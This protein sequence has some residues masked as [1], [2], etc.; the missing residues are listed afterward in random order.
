MRISETVDYI[1]NKELVRENESG[2]AFDFYELINLISIILGCT[3]M[4]FKIFDVG[5]PTSDFSK[6]TIFKISNQV[7]L[8]DLQFFKFI[9]SAA[10]VH[11]SNTNR[12]IGKTK[13]KNEFFPYAIW[14]YKSPFS[15]EL[16]SDSCDLVLLSWSGKANSKSEYYR[17]CSD[18]FYEF[19]QKV[20]DTIKL[21]MPKVYAI[22]N[23][24]VKNSSFKRIKSEK[25]FASYNDYL[26]YLYCLLKKH[27]R[28]GDFDDAGLTI[29]RGIFQNDLIS[30]EFK[31]YLKVKVA[32]F[33]KKMHEN[34]E[35]IGQAY[36]FRDLRLFDCFTLL[37]PERA[38]YVGEKFL[39]YL[40]SE[41][42][43]EIISGQKLFFD[44]YQKHGNPEFARNLLMTDMKQL[45]K[46]D[47][48]AKARTYEDLFELTLEATYLFWKERKELC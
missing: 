23:E 5:F 16:F 12:F 18:E 2:E 45:F 7:R 1:N 32:L 14:K 28:T 15:D 20:V 13:R 39:D 47:E 10:S 43:Q 4:L 46:N 27:S 38:S 31:D 44:V 19:A 26:D 41:A 29:T 25:A 37:N 48:L 9:R 30:T 11:P 6:K 3:E 40:G 42:K 33:V 8:N 22:R 17:L 21:L 34:P 35:E 36:I 24:Y